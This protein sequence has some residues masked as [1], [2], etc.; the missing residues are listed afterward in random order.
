MR[1]DRFGR[2]LDNLPNGTRY[3]EES[4]ADIDNVQ[5]FYESG[6]LGA[7]PDEEASEQL[8]DSFG[9]KK[10][11]GD[12]ASATPGLSESGQGKMALLY[13]YVLQ[14][15]PTA[16]R[17]AQR[18]GDCVSF[19]YANACD[20]VRA[21]EILKEGQAESWKAELS[22]EFL[23]WG[24][25]HSG[26]GASCARIGKFVSQD[27]GMIARGNY[28]QFGIDVTKYDPKVGRDGRRGPPASLIEFSKKNQMQ[29]LTRIDSIEEARDAIVNGHALSCCSNMSFSN[30]RDGRGIAKRTRTGWNHAMAWTAVDARSVADGGHPEGPLFLVQNSWGRWNSGGWGVGYGRCPTGCFWIVAKDADAL[31]RQNGS[32]AVADAKGFKPKTLPSLGARGR[33]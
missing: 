14:L 6:Y 25:G 27:A 33:L 28:P 9:S 32:F 30:K 11:F 10:T 24:R 26:E 15:N 23:Y 4:Q 29:V 20:A 18:R 3:W 1:K 7:Y 5:K 8:L 16:Y 19:S 13:R 17:T 22:P 31:I 21:V 2:R 12:W